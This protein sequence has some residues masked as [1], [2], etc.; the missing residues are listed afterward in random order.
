[1]QFR[2]SRTTIEPSL[3]AF[4]FVVAG[5]LAGSET[6]AARERQLTNPIAALMLQTSNRPPRRFTRKI[7]W[8]AALSC[9]GLTVEPNKERLSTP[10]AFNSDS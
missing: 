8:A 1:M 5:L 4:A 7:D 6:P 10:A 9:F 3:A 2:R